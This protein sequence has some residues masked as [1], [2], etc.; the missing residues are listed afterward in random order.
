MT[1]KHTLEHVQ[2]TFKQKDC[3]LLETEYIN[4]TTKIRYIC[5]CGNESSITFCNF[6]A[7]HLC[8]KCA[9][10]KGPIK[11]FTDEKNNLICDICSK[12]YKNR[13][14]LFYHKR[15][16]HTH[17]NCEEKNCSCCLNPFHSVI[18]YPKKIK[19]TYD[20]C[21]ECRFL[22]KKLNARTLKND[23]YIYNENKRYL[24]SLGQAIEVCPVYDCFDK[25]CQEHK[26]EEI[27]FCRGTKC[28]NSYIQNGYNFC[29]ICREKNDMVKN[30]TRQKFKD[31]KIKLGGRCV[32]CGEQDLFK[33][34]FDHIDEKLKTKQITRMVPKDWDEEIKNIQ[35]LCNICHR[36]KNITTINNKKKT[37][38]IYER[39][40]KKIAT[41]IKRE[42]GGCQICGWTHENDQILSYV[43]D[44]DHIGEKIKQV[45]N[46]HNYTPSKIL[47][48]IKN[49]RLLCRA[50]HQ[51]HTCLQRGGKML[52][53][54]YTEEEIEN[55]RKKLFC[56]ELNKKFQETILNTVSKMEKKYL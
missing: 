9:F 43:L 19:T 51:L 5:K 14:E 18:T 25:N 11:L 27:S 31:L 56:P 41:E 34:E 16:K 50:C 45:S 39:K 42:I 46:F 49:T 12:S 52:K 3:T 47:N 15:E 48:E 6:K 28:L 40:S 38:P 22:R 33:L 44:F 37:K 36:I 17:F 29:P 4:N 55:F 23:S 32:Q 26:K 20:N 13:T 53:F 35:L 21:E 30:K 2:E 8:K 54:Y 24:I 1:K 7:G 10:I